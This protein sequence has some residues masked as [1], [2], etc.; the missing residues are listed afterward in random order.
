MKN[1]TI[2]HDLIDDQIAR[3]YAVSHP[4]YTSKRFNRFCKSEHKGHAQGI[5]P[6]VKWKFKFAA[7]LMEAWQIIN[8][9]SK[10]HLINRD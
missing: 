2:I 10:I 6:F 7:E 8:E 1:I 5:I 4:D 3:L 9:D